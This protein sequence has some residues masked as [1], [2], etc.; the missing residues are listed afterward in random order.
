MKQLKLVEDLDVNDE[1]VLVPSKTSMK[2][3]IKLLA[4]NPDSAMLVQ[5]KKSGKI[6]GAVDN[7]D[8]QRF[9]AAGQKVKKGNVDRWMGTNILEIIDKTP[10]AR[11]S[12]LLPEKKPDAV[13]VNDVTGKFKG[14]LSPAD[15]KLAS[16][17]TKSL[18][19]DKPQDLSEAVENKG[20][21]GPAGA[22]NSPPKPKRG[23]PKSS[24]NMKVES[25]SVPPPQEQEE[26]PQLIIEEIHEDD[27]ISNVDAFFGRVRGRS[28]GDF[29]D[30]QGKL[31]EQAWNE[32]GGN[33]SGPVDEAEYAVDTDTTGPPTGFTPPDLTI[34]EGSN[35][36]VQ[37]SSNDRPC[38]FCG[39]TI[40]LAA[41]KCRFCKE[42]LDN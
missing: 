33:A 24:R 3:V 7:E 36:Q 5:D 27:Q 20:P 28:V 25:H 31:A 8:V 35:L 12:Q 19:E 4:D 21:Q 29:N 6:I 39:E 32:T 17:S 2:K 16:S 22:D 30:P 26:A 42:W 13:I 11:L 1:F 41:K 14:F 18:S 40:K 15:Y 23:P 9:E 10:L 34:D 37:S 38:P